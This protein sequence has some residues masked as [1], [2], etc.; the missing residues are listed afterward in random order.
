[1]DA[2]TAAPS[3]KVNAKTK[4]I[5]DMSGG[6]EREETKQRSGNKGKKEGKEREKTSTENDVR[7]AK[8]VADG[9]SVKTTRE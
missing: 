9:E 7:S 5:K 2:G 3:G 4:L 1:M 8:V 6:N